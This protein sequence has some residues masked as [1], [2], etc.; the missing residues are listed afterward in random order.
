[1]TA[2]VKVARQAGAAGAVISRGPGEPLQ[3][4]PASRQR[5]AILIVI[6][7]AAAARSARQARA[8]GAV[9]SHGAGEPLQPGP[10]SRQ[11]DAI[12]I[13]IVL[14]AAANLA[15]LH[16]PMFVIVLAAI[17]GL[18]RDSQVIPRMLTWYFGPA[19][20]WYIRRRNRRYLRQQRLGASSG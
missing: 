11:R 17:R 7:L 2:N 6:V 5:D 12:L 1:M 10:A 18:V 19:P 4:G 13:V 15:L 8:A 20:A 3:P 16:G 14:A 9:I